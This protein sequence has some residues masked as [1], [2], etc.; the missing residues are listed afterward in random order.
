MGS[1]E[2]EVVE[3]PQRPLSGGAGTISR[4]LAHEVI[5]KT[6]VTAVSAPDLGSA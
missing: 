5:V 2:A 1:K 4:E 6:I 3:E